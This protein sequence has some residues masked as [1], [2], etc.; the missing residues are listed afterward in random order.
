MAQR[1]KNELVMLLCF[2]LVIIVRS[3]FG[4]L[5]IYTSGSCVSVASR[6]AWLLQ[7]QLLFSE[8]KIFVGDL[9]KCRGF[10]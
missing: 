6:G 5:G 10:S 9:W 4:F 7:C 3:A 1:I 2:V 8:I